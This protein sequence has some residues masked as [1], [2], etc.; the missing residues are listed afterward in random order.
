MNIEIFDERR[1][2]LGEGPTS[3]GQTNNHVMWIDILSFK[4]LWR[5]IISGEFGSF[6]TPAEVGFALPRKNFGVVVG[7]S[8]GATLRDIDGTESPLPS[9]LEAESEPLKIPVRW[10]DA[11]VAP[12][13][14]LFAGTMAFD[15]KEGAGSLY[16]FSKDGKSITKLLS[17]V[18]ISNGLDWSPDGSYFYYI[19]TLTMQ[20][21]RFDYSD[22]GITN[23]R[24]LVTF[25]EKD[26]MPDGGCSDS[27]GGMWVGFWG[28]SHIRRYDSRGKKTHEIKMPVK[29]I[30][31][32]AFA[33]ENLDMLVITTA[34]TDDTE[35]PK[36]GMTFVIDPGIKGNKTV[37]FN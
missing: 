22:H 30:T 6:E 5:D 11:K 7:H 24:T 8:S 14:E 17:S 37:L 18:S 32:C 10:N 27:G 28:G 1:C 25:E 33:G 16:K 35:N 12:N 23:R 21:D 3:S 29:N 31:S 15:G 4:V 26:G 2:V 13:G 20:L 9:W 36:S 19:D 34:S